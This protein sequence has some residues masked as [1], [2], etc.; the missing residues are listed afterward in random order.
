MQLKSFK[1]GLVS[2]F[3]IVS[4]FI[5]CSS[6]LFAET[7]ITADQNRLFSIEVR[8][9]EMTDVLRALAQ[10]SGYNI[11]IGDGVEGKISLSLKD[12]PSKEAIEIL[13]KSKGLMFTI[14]NNVFWVGKT[15][16]MTESM[17]TEIVRLNNADPSVT[18][19]QL[20]PILSTEGAAFA[21]LRTN[22]VVIRD[23]PR[24]IENAKK[25]IKE[26][27]TRTSQVEIEARIV[28]ANSN[29]AR[30]LGIQWGGT[31]TSGRDVI[32]GSQLLPSS[33][34]DRN[35]AVNL[36]AASP[37]AGLGII[38]GNLS[39]KLFLDLELSA[40]ETKGDLKI[41]SRPRI[42]TLNNRPATI[43]SGLTFRVKLSQAIVTGTTA[44]TTTT[45]GTSLGGLEEIKTG[46]DLTVTPQI[47]SDGYILLNISTNKSDPDFSRTVDGIPGV[48]E[49]SASTYVLVRDGDTVVIGGLYKSISSEQ[50]NAVPFLSRIPVIGAL[51]QNKSKDLQNEEL[52][53][54][55]TPKIVNYEN[56]MEVAH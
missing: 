6:D 16:D 55:I 11:I 33:S 35:F 42:S 49:K 17:S 26:L 14:K 25:L 37:T 48:A 39:S 10:Q 1:I 34:A 52:L 29:F 4:A 7:K 18:I 5:S 12:I 15:V 21:D 8:D 56:R 31:Y 38:L 30:Q 53:V 41:I 54:F 19:G 2:F 32:T 28:E 36:P 9:A 27:D 13:I 47:S 24:N 50:N 3:F 23:Q 20:K 44:T 40:A 51:F 22:S 46:I 45:S 43:H